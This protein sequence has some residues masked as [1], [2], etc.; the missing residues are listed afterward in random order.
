MAKSNNGVLVG[1]LS[2][3]TLIGWIVALILNLNGRTSLGSFHIRQALFL[4]LVSMV[5]MF[6]PVI[7]W[8]LQVVV[9]IFAIMGIIYAAQGKE[10]ELPLIGATAQKLFKGL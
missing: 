4:G 9:L 2:Y 5:L 1:V 3:I 8:F 10:T 7:G 6:I